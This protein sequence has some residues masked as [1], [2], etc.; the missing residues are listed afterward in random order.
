MNQAETSAVG[1]LLVDDQ[2]PFRDALRDLV[3]AT[4]GFVLLGEADSGEAAV[5]AVARLAPRLVIMDKRMPGVGGVEATRQ[6]KSRHPEIVVILTSVEEGADE[7]LLRSCGA[8]GFIRKR[9]FSPA[10]LVDLW[11]THGE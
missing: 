8:S 5:D 3:A 2:A 6:I 9:D 4:E 11:R 10:A 7:A 1:V